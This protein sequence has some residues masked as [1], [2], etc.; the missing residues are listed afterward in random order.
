MMFSLISKNLGPT[1]IARRRGGKHLLPLLDSIIR[2]DCCMREYGLGKRFRGNS[3]F[4]FASCFGEM[5]RPS[6]YGRDLLKER[7]P[8][9]SYRRNDGTSDFKCLKTFSNQL[10]PAFDTEYT[11]R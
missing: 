8:C 9:G 1:K 3:S 4:L 2:Q 5:N 11:P 6:R 10:L 7:R